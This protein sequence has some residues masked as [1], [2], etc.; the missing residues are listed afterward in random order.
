M[1][2]GTLEP[3][4]LRERAER[5]GQTPTGRIAADRDATRVETQRG[6][7]ALQP[8]Q[9]VERILEGDGKAVLGAQ[10]ILD[11]KDRDFAFVREV[12]GEM[13]VDRHV[14][15]DPAAAMEEEQHR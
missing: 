8:A 2:R 7:F 12:A 3:L 1:I 10:A 4:I 5:C 14:A 6:A 13:V 9:R 11:G 15:D